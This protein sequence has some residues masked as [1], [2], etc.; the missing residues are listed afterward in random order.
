MGDLLVTNGVIYS[1]SEFSTTGTGFVFSVTPTGT[2]TIHFTATPT[3]GFPPTT[4]QFNTPAVDDYGNTIVYWH[5]DFGD[6]GTNLAQ[7]PLHTYSNNITYV[8]S[9]IATNNNGASVIGIGPVIVLAYPTSI[10]NGGFEA[11]SFTNWTRSGNYAGSS[12]S[13]AAQYKHSGTYGAQLHALTTL[14]YL[15]QTL[16]TVPGNVYLIS[17]WLDSPF[18]SNPN[19][20]SVTWDGNVLMDL[21]NIPNIG[22]T[23]IQF[24]VT[25]TSNATTLQLGYRSDSTYLGLDDVSVV[26][27]QPLISKLTLSGANVVLNNSGGISNRTYVL[28]SSTN[29]AQPLNQW[30]PISTNVVGSNGIFNLTVTNAV[31]PNSPREFYILQVR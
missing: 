25:A 18:A 30:I 13:S 23:N 24:F 17:L 16:T 1:T 10:L 12:I 3:N 19:E 26:S 11:G 4:V 29:V 21:T 22:W 8:P 7:A 5:W 14:G 6:G 28:L 2:P 15:S 31:P 27:A 20:F 9:L